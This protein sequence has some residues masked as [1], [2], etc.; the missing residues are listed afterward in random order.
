MSCKKDSTNTY[1]WTQ[2]HRRWGCAPGRKPAVDG[3]FSLRCQVTWRVEV[4]RT[5]IGQEFQCLWAMTDEHK[6][7]TFSKTA[8]C[9]CSASTSNII[10]FLRANFNTPT[11]I[12]SPYIH[13]EKK[14]LLHFTN[15]T[16]VC[17]QTQKQQ[18][19]SRTRTHTH[20]HIYAYIYI[21]IYIGWL[22]RLIA[23]QTLWAIQCRIFSIFCIYGLL[24]IN[25][26]EIIFVIFT[27]I[28]KLVE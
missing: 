15:L 3:V 7:R 12:H 8:T 18:T 13:F 21:Y 5:N 22:F 24:F 17:I 11:F 28:I 16:H 10:V 25:T 26:S 2:F 9:F 27:R 6:R 23:Y 4:L 19:K 1:R 14:N 20:P